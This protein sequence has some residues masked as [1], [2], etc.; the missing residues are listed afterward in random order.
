[1]TQW[2]FDHLYF[3]G[4][5]THRHR[6]AALLLPAQ[7]NNNNHI[8]QNSKL[9]SRRGVIAYAVQMGQSHLQQQTTPRHTV[10]FTRAHCCMSSSRCI[11][12]LI[13]FSHWWMSCWASRCACCRFSVV[14]SNAICLDRKG[15]SSHSEGGF[16]NCFGLSAEN[17]SHIT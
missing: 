2:H 16:C 13:V 4:C 8:H 12:C 11:I 3:T 15:S 1:M 7:H 9:L 5:C 17:Q 14:L 10:H 6:A